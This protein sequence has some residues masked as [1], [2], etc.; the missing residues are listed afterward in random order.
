MEENCM[1]M[2][3]IKIER[4]E[5]ETISREEARGELER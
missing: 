4:N 3:I 1:G 2:G 5:C